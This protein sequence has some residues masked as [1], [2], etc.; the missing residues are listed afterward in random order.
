M[1]P[2][3]P[4]VTPIAKFIQYIIIQPFSQ[5][6]FN[7]HEKLIKGWTLLISN[8]LNFQPNYNNYVHFQLELG[9]EL[10]KVENA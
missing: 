1:L 7:E 3:K 10:Q 9:I 6:Q 5:P 4:A 8:N 2:L